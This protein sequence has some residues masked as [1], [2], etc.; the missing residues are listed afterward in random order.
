MIIQI[1]KYRLITAWFATK[2]AP[3]RFYLSV[4]TSNM[5]SNLE[6]IHNVYSCGLLIF[7]NCI[8]CS[9]NRGNCTPC[10]FWSLFHDVSDIYVSGWM[11]L[12][13]TITWTSKQI[14]FLLKVTKFIP[15]EC[16]TYCKVLCAQNCKLRK[17]NVYLLLN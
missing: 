13:Q 14:M 4:Q 7:R 6:F 1:L 5:I 11:H 16:V 17:Y 3:G 9:H 8:L 12:K 15:D 2:V 10:R